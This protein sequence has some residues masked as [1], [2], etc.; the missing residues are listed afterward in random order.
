MGTKNLIDETNADKT[1]LD[2]IRQ[3]GEESPAKKVV[4]G[5]TYRKLRPEV[6]VTLE[7]IVYHLELIGKT[8]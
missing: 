2:D 3:P 8:L 1:D 4:Q 5:V 6:K 7:K